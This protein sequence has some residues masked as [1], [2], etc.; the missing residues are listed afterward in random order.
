MDKTVTTDSS[1]HLI[2][3][4]EALEELYG[5]PVQVALDK[6]IDYISDHYR[7]F[8]EAS[9]FVLVATNGP[10]GLDCSPRGDPK[11]FVKVVD[12]KTLLMPDRKGNNRTDTLHNIVRDPRLSLLFLIPGVNETLRVIGRAVISTDP[13]LRDQFVIQG[14]SPATVLVISVESV[15]FQ[16]PKA[17]V[18][19]KLWDPSRHIDRKELPSNGEMLS[20]LSANIAKPEDWDLA[21]PGLLR[22][23]IY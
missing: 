5:P 17:L 16:C 18:R 21:Y 1:D 8:I 15:Y 9:P 13:D 4:T 23:T 14:K 12:E 7:A 20:A 11:G 22:K 3:T 6:E 19:S 10:E 2:T